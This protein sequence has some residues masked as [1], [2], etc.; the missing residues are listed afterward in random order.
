M[1]RQFLAVSALFLLSAASA[2]G[3]C[4]RVAKESFSA[5]FSVHAISKNQTATCAFNPSGGFNDKTIAIPVPGCVV[6]LSILKINKGNQLPTVNK[7][8]EN[9]VKIYSDGALCEKPL[10]V[11]LKLKLQSTATECCEV[12]VS[13]KGSEYQYCTKD[14]TPK[15]IKELPE[16]NIRCSS[17]GRRWKI[18]G[19]K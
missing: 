13:Q 18:I 8:R 9:K 3:D 12:A 4:E 6:E 2:K 11:K 16:E 14:S 5:E 7:I 17:E 10:G 1:K 15:F 19:E